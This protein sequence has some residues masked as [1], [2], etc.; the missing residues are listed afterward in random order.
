M[1]ETP[2]PLA[3][4][5]LVAVCFVPIE[6]P[7]AEGRQAREYLESLWEGCGRLGMA[8]PVERLGVPLQLRWPTKDTGAGAP[9]L[10]AAKERPGDGPAV[11][12]AL[13]FAVHDVVALTA[14]LAP[15]RGR[16]TLAAWQAL[17]GEWTAAVGAEPLPPDVVG[18]ALVFSAL[19]PMDEALEA[20]VTSSLPGCT[21][22]TPS[23]LRTDS[24]LFHWEVTDDP[25]RRRLGLLAPPSRER[26]LDRW[27]WWDA[28]HGESALQ[29][30][31]LAMLLLQ[32]LKLRYQQRVYLARSLQLR[33][34]L[35]T[36]DDAL[37]DL[38]TF[39][40]GLEQ[41]RPDRF[42]M[43]ELLAAEDRLVQDQAGSG[44]L[45]MGMS[46]L[47]ELRR[48]ALIADANV[49]ALMPASHVGEPATLFSQD[50]KIAAS[51]AEQIDDDLVYAEALQDRTREAQRLAGLRIQ[52]ATQHHARDQARLT[53]FQAT[54]VGSLLAGVGAINTV[55]AKVDL[56]EGLR[57]PVV[58]VLAASVLALPHLI[59]DWPE[60]YR[61]LDYGVAAVLGAAAFWLAAGV[62]GLGDAGEGIAA[63][64]GALVLPAVAWLLER[65][66]AARERPWLRRRP[67]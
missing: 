63:V 39:L 9:R 28:E 17:D 1:A 48:T 15:N 16:D 4:A 46:G 40:G 6:A 31:G 66:V 10:L 43:D 60:R 64:A 12:Q 11:Y 14:V 29:Q 2:I 22:R 42:P 3:N 23:S 54:L 59:V 24:G 30:Q 32:V 57:L 49:R 53:L 21:G 7:P 8:A 18:E 51:L 34:R 52:H 36:V 50:L 41:R 37:S 27:I 55:K 13:A 20:A 58:A 33:E 67:E 65:V 38:L 44:G 26:E 47:K 62:L 25:R 19:S 45:L 5:A 56:T 35:R 61:T